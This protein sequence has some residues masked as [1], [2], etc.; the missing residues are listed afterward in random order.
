MIPLYLKQKNKY[1]L[2]VADLRDYLCDF[3]QRVQPL[4][5]FKENFKIHTKNKVIEGTATEIKSDAA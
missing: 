5:N 1:E 2:Y 3:F 4:I